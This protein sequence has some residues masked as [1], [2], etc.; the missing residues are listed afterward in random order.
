M[1]R[2]YQS[3]EELQDEIIYLH[4]RIDSLKRGIVSFAIGILLGLIGQYLL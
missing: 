3:I 1:D 4:R 2:Q